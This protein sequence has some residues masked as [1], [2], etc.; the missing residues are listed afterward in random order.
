ME[1][2]AASLVSTTLHLREKNMNSSRELKK[3]ELYPILVYE[4]KSE[5][6]IMRKENNSQPYS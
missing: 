1:S 6:N 5:K 4:A 3:E 2:N